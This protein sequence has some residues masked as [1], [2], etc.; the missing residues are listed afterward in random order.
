MDEFLAR[1]G[2]ALNTIAR[3][4][5]MDWNKNTTSREK[6]LMP[7]NKVKGVIALCSALYVFFL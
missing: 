5:A 6:L 2:K 1:I 4:K 7:V 3:K